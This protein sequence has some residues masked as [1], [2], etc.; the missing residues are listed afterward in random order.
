MEHEMEGTQKIRI[1][2]LAAQEKS[3]WEQ[4]WLPFRRE[5]LH[6]AAEPRRVR[7]AIQMDSGHMA[8]SGHT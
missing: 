3:G 6:C 7:E 4:G 1:K 2:M 5:R 8:L